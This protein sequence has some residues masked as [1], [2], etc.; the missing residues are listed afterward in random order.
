MQLKLKN[1]FV[2]AAFIDSDVNQS[3]CGWMFVKTFRIKC[4]D[5][6]AAFVCVLNNLS[7]R[8][9]T[10]LVT[11]FERAVVGKGVL[12]SLKRVKLVVFLF[13]LSSV[14]IFSYV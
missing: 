8:I 5:A 12:H 4:S 3:D 9:G 7:V 10:R 11:R 1:V 2:I 6:A 13:Q 14:L